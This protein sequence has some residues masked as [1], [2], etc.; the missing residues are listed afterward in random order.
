VSTAGAREHVDIGQRFDPLFDAHYQEIY[1]FCIR[2]LGADDAEDATAEVFAVAWRRID[3]MPSGVD[4]RVWLYG[5]AQR[6][7]GNHYR[8]RRRR[9]GLLNKLLLTR[10]IGEPDDATGAD[11]DAR[12][13]A[14]LSSLS[15]SDQDLLRLTTWDG[16]T[17]SE[18]AHV[19]GIKEN[20]VDQRTHRARMRLRD[21]YDRLEPEPRPVTTKEASA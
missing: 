21:R 2:R 6:V 19:L 9:Q 12:V 17:R 7:V 3:D 4:D 1:R 5:V 14:A 15:G 20:A 16:L 10:S 18:I 13:L 8:S 11:A